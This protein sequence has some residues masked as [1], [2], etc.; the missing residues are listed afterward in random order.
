MTRIEKIELRFEKAFKGYSYSKDTWR[1]EVRLAL[2]NIACGYYNCH[3][4]VDVLVRAKLITPKTR[5]MNSDGQL[6]LYYFFDI[7][8]Q[9]KNAEIEKCYSEIKDKEVTI[10]K[11]WDR[12]ERYQDKYI[13][14]LNDIENTI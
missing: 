11:Y 8:E 1:S 3:S 4:I 7:L 14:L 5:R 12:S 10:K 9:E 13:K 2:M 6:C